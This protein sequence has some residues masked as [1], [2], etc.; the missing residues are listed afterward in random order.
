M[1]N[2]FYTPT[3]APAAGNYKP[4]LPLSLTVGGVPV[5]VQSASLA[6]NRFGIFQVSFIVPASVPTGRQPV[7]I[8]VGGV[9]SRPANITVQ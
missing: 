3:T 6:A 8:T 9:A 4:V 1:L 2:T 5:F 7:V